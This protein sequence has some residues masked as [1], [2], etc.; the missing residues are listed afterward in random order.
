MPRDR[1][2]FLPDEV[3]S[4]VPNSLDRG[5]HR[6]IKDLETRVA[7]LENVDTGVRVHQLTLGF[8]TFSKLTLNGSNYYGLLTLPKAGAVLD[9]YAWTPEAFLATG[10]PRSGYV[11]LSTMGVVVG[12]VALANGILT[13]KN[14]YNAQP[15]WSAAAD[16]GT[17]LGTGDARRSN[18]L[19]ATA[20]TE[21]LMKV[22]PNN[23]GAAYGDMSLLYQGLLEIV[24][25]TYEP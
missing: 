7:A 2:N 5:L 24:L 13:T 12:T 1:E 22:T 9:C 16:K 15:T 8:K 19:S 10:S 4:L 20:A 6:R 11:A 21:I 17:D 23:T 14:A 25:I 18:V 3:T